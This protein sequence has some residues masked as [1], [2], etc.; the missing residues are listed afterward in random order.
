MTDQIEFVSKNH[1]T[2][3]YKRFEYL[4]IEKAKDVLRF[5]ESFPGY[6]I[7]PLAV[8]K[9]LAKAV[10]VSSVCVKD[11]SYRFGLNAFK[12]LGGSYAVGQVIAKRI[13]LQPDQIDYSI[14]TSEMTRSKLGEI[15]FV[16]A[17]D[18][19]HG[20]GIAW[21]ASALGQ[22]SV[23][24][25]P[26]G[27]STERLENIREAGAE[28][29]ITDLSYDDAVRFAQKMASENGWVFVQDT[30]WEGYEEIPTWIMQGYMTM[31]YE[32]YKQLDVCGEG[33]PT[34]IFLQAGVGSMAA[35]MAGF[36]AQL[37]DD[38]RPK[39]I[40]VEPNKADCLFKTAKADDGILRFVT[41]EMDTIMAGLACGE[42][43]TIAW[44]VLDTYADAFISCPDFISAK[45][46]RILG[47]PMSSDLR[48][49][50]GE[51]GSVGV[52]IFVEIMTNPELSHIKEQLSLK[53]DSRVLFF[54]TE[55]D[56][57]KVGYRA[58]VWDGKYPS[59]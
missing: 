48:V 56:T 31:A 55:G 6:Q 20:R 18:G 9:G 57:D 27:S 5:H 22:K 49:I 25:M 54:N 53:Q 1:K 36:F 13:G 16:T 17:T 39:I 10:D 35:A 42:P 30:A 28:A 41:A 37:C 19:N 43:S 47:N 34:H 33:K 11:E 14:L 46:M 59:C 8:L 4:S 23:V 21:T 3:L 32:S 45:G 51:S 44:D 38:E 52:G 26:K 40:I 29:E 12:V 15:T 24:Y 2:S 58:V 7:T 50:S